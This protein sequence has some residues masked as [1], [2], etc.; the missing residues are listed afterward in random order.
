MAKSLVG[1][2]AKRAGQKLKGGTKSA[3]RLIEGGQRVRMSKDTGAGVMREVASPKSARAGAKQQNT[4][5]ARQARK[6]ESKAAADPKQPAMGTPGATAEAADVPSTSSVPMQ[7]KPRREVTGITALGREYDGLTPNAKRAERAKGTK[8]KYYPVFKQRNM[9]TLPP[10]KK[11]TTA[12]KSTTAK[13]P[14]GSKKDRLKSVLQKKAGGKTIPQ[15]SK[16]KGVRALVASGPKGKQAAKDMGFA[17]AKK[18]G[19]IVAAMKG[20]QIVAMMYDD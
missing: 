3:T 14:T 7:R 12:K 4:R 9:Q 13:K 19:R 18:G 1:N 11:P 17:V 5:A 16:G 20:G 6:A 8:S 15:G 10:V 2:I